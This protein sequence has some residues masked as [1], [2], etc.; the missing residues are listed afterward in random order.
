VH[1]HSTNTFF[2]LFFSN[3]L[4]LTGCGALEAYEA[5]FDCFKDFE[6]LW[7][8]VDEDKDGELSHLCLFI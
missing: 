3:S 1:T 6:L 5:I 4:S 2:I 7:E 8:F